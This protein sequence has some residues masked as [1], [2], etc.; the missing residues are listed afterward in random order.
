MAWEWLYA[1]PPRQ[2]L[3][4]GARPRTSSRACPPAPYLASFPIHPVHLSPLPMLRQ[5]TA[6]PSPKP[7]L[8]SSPWT[9]PPSPFFPPPSLRLILLP[10]HTPTRLHDRPLHSPQQWPP[11]RHGSHTPSPAGPAQPSTACLQNCACRL[12]TISRP[13][14]RGEPPH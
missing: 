7:P 6:K 13:P 14:S 11:R 4:Q 3:R 10:T 1:D 2:G 9:Q 8:Q 5:P 12:T